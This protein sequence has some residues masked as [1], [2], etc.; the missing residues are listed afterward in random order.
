MKLKSLTL[1][2]A[3]ALLMATAACQKQSP[4]APTTPSAGTTA[5]T[6]VT[7][8]T[9]VTLT[10]PTLISPTDGTSIANVKQPV[11]L[12]IGN[13]VTTGTTPLVYGIEVATDP[14]F[15]S[16]AYSKD[17]VPEGAN[18]QTSLTIDKIGPG[19]TYYWRAHTVS[20]AAVGPSPAPKKFIIGPQVILQVPVLSDPGSNGTVGQTPTLTVN[21]VQRSGPADKVFYRFEVSQ[22]SD[23][24][25]LVFVASGVPERTDVPYTQAS[26]T[27][28]LTP[29]TTYWWRVQATDPI[30]QVTTAY[31][32]AN[33]FKV[34]QPFDFTK[35]IFWDNPPDVN[36][37]PATAT[38]TLADTSGEFIIVDFDR[39]TINPWPSVGF[40]SGDLQYTLGMC[41]NLSQQWNC[42]AAIQFWNGRDLTAGGHPWEVGINWYYDQRWGAMTG[43][44]PDQGEIVGIWV[45]A[46]NLRDS[47]NVIAK[48]RSE[49]VMMP[50]GSKYTNGAGV[51]APASMSVLK[52]VSPVRR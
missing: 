10:T 20:G 25:S 16:K 42:S 49:V 30:N 18:G 32:S 44:Q 5:Q 23:F 29:N 46:G 31:S 14:G 15:T 7:D 21:N 41:F 2:S 45:G 43:H 4:A 40:G 22:T 17:N 26:V 1:W 6:A 47:G 24:A 33:P 51:M 3:L 50:F 38:I 28:K 11:T 19:Q 13:A 36:L 52:L 37:W 39:R 12:V 35:A 9:G 34:A 8:K 27:T 48:E